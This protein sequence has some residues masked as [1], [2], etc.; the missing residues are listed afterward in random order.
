MPAN[1]IHQLKKI[2]S[3]KNFKNNKN[4]INYIT[5]FNKNLNTL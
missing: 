5:H 1:V 4:T 2:F 3:I